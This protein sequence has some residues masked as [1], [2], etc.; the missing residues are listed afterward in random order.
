MAY[1]EKVDRFTSLDSVASSTPGTVVHFLVPDS[2]N[3]TKHQ[4][5]PEPG[6]EMLAC[7]PLCQKK[8]IPVTTNTLGRATNPVR[9]IHT[10]LKWLA[11][12]GKILAW[13]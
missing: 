2:S 9:A 10:T 7:F 12:E 3:S 4:Q 11:S 8:K 6:V 5:V 13:L 1:L